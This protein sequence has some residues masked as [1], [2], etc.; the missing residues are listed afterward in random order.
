MNASVFPF[1]NIIATHEVAS[2]TI[3]G[4]W[5]LLDPKQ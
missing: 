2:R 5:Q 3:P 1:D 4:M